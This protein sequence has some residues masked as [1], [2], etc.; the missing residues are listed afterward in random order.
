MHVPKCYFSVFCKNSLSLS[1]RR[2][3]GAIWFL[4]FPFLAISNCWLRKLKHFLVAKGEITDSIRQCVCTTH[5]LP[6]MVT[7]LCATF[8]ISRKTYEIGKVFLG[9]NSVHKLGPHYVSE[10]ADVWIRQLVLIIGLNDACCLTQDLV[11]EM[12][13]S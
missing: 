10:I 11:Q 6:D 1:F 13:R 5:K 9:D 12:V 8:D 2:Q 4:N 7:A 3:L